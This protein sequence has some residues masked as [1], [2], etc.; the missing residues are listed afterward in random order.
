[1]DKQSVF[2]LMT[3]RVGLVCRG[4]RCGTN[5]TQGGNGSAAAWPFSVCVSVCVCDKCLCLGL[6]LGQRYQSLSLSLIGFQMLIKIPCSV[7]GSVL[8]ATI[9]HTQNDAQI[10]LTHTHTQRQCGF[11]KEKTKGT[12]KNFWLQHRR[13]DTLSGHCTFSEAINTTKKFCK[14]IKLFHM[15][16]FY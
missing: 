1:M 14:S 8:P 2:E 16:G 15:Q 9:D 12:R 5:W 11:H 13:L 7:P 4:W 6:C 10:T 3:T